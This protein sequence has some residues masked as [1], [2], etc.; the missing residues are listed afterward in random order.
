MESLS[1][2]K[3]KFIKSLHQKKYRDSH[4]CY[5]IEGEKM[6]QELIQ[7]YSDEIL[8]LVI[9]KEFISEFKISDALILET[10]ASGL[11]QISTLKT[12]NKALAIVQMR[13]NQ[14]INVPFSIVLDG[15]QDPGN[16]G[17]ILRLA[18]WYRVEQVI[19]SPETV[20]IYNPKVVQAT[21]GAILRINVCYE[22]L[23]SI[24]NSSNQTVY[25]AQMEGQ[26]IYS[27]SLTPSGY[28]VMGNE[29]KGI[30]ESVQNL[31]N[32]PITIPRRGEAESLN[33]GVATGIILSEFYRNSF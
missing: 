20:D 5:I 3:I 9:Q 23:T 12:P 21:M 4:Q 17:T 31:I 30:S 22:D 27:K 18:D 11:K 29:G 32:E 15:I 8:Q 26:N 25:G 2:N 24:L 33:V 19:C 6:V 10:D 16:M 1:K 7:N 28:L 13:K 14:L